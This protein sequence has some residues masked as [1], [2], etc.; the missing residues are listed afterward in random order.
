MDPTLWQDYYPFGST[1]VLNLTAWSSC[2]FS[3]LSRTLPRRIHNTGSSKTPIKG[4]A[5]KG[6]FR[7][8]ITKRGNDTVG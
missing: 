7:A 1:G 6:A 3:S 8:A 5:S 4:Y 2:T